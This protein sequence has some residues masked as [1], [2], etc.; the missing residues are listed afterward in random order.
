[1]ATAV[2]SPNP[3][4]A[5]SGS[6]SP[7]DCQ[8][9]QKL[10][11]DFQ[12]DL[13]DKQL[14]AAHAATEIGKSH[15]AAAML[16]ICDDRRAWTK[17]EDMRTLYGQMH[18][19]IS[20]GLVNDVGTFQKCVDDQ[21]KSSEDLA[22]GYSAAVG[23]MKETC[24]KLLEVCRAAKDYSI[25][26]KK[27]CNATSK[28][29]L[30]KILGGTKDA[31]KLKAEG[32]EK[33]AETLVDAGD[34]VI[35]TAVKA[36]GIYSF[37]NAKSLKPCIDDLKKAADAFKGD[38]ESGWKMSEDHVKAALK[39]LDSDLPKLSAGYF[40]A[41]KAAANELAIGTVATY[42]DEFPP[43]PLPSESLDHICQELTKVFT[44]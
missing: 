8:E 12:K 29:A 17:A 6:T 11:E 33:T 23:K 26:V 36:T 30:E 32:F 38:T 40:E 24:S 9:T 10:V 21:I 16:A 43:A 35:E 2:K 20:I 15:E 3:A 22:K 42:L 28:E 27:T 25:D 18:F 44:P 34:Q 14:K 1:M 4:P 5:G 37:V 31:L 19:S 7:A 13:T 39:A 41:K